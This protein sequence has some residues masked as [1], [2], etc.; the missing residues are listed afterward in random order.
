M[1]LSKIKKFL[2]ILIAMIF[3][4]QIGVSAR[5]PYQQ[6]NFNETEITDTAAASGFIPD[7]VIDGNSL[8]IG[9]F[10]N[11]SDI[12]VATNEIFVIDNGN[13]RIIVLNKDFSLN[14]TIQLKDKEGK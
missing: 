13:N 10:N 1:R 3:V 14:R 4:F 9:N 12:Y 11:T 8:G 5:V 6:Y 2:V 7:R